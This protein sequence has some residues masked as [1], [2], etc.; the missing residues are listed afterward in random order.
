MVL[1]HLGC[2]N[3][4]RVGFDNLDAKNGWRF[5]D[6]LPHYADGSVDG[7][8][9]SHALMYVEEQNWRAVMFE[10]F[11]VL[12]RGGVVR[13]TED[14][15]ETPGSLR[16]QM[17]WPGAAI[18]TGPNMVLDSLQQAGFVPYLCT[19]KD[20]HFVNDS[21]LIAHREHKTTK[22]FFYAEGVKP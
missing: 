6:G 13:I 12:R 11:R 17:P 18:L 19:A 16:K 7:I 2:G 22:Y 8:T 10:F 5:E 1:L 4:L 20:T 14:D 9:I 15:C 21:L 3:D